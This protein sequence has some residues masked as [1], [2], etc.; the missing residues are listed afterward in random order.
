MVGS[1]DLVVANQEGEDTAY[2]QTQGRVG[3]EGQ[4]DRE[5]HRRDPILEEG[6]TYFGQTQD[7]EDLGGNRALVGWRVENEPG[8]IEK[9]LA[10]CY[11]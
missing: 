5:D 9:V 11:H 2:R 10:C 3:Q 8:R 1:S 4:E 7:P 6:G